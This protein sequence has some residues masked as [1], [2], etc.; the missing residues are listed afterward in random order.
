MG[1]Y[2]KE[3][4]KILRDSLSYLDHINGKKRA[5]PPAPGLLTPSSLTSRATTVVRL[6]PPCPSPSTEQRALGLSMRVER[7]SLQ[8]VQEKLEQKKLEKEMAKAA[9]PSA[10][11]NTFLIC[12]STAVGSFACGD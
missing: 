11:I 12:R 10:L 7:S 1:F 8:Q 9:A 2:C 4:G 6:C 5:R 3:S